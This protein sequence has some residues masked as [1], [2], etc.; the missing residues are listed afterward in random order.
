MSVV[1]RTKL[2]ST[3]SLSEHVRPMAVVPVLPLVDQVILPCGIFTLRYY[4]YLSEDKNWKHTPTTNQTPSSLSL[5]LSQDP[6]PGPPHPKTP[7]APD[8]RRVP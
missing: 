2:K 4:R 1:R 3:S 6:N 8:P 5:S 7:P